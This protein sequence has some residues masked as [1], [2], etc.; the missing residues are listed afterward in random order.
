MAAGKESVRGR[1]AESWRLLEV[2]EVVLSR[3]GLC[4]SGTAQGTFAALTF[5]GRRM[6]TGQTV[7]NINML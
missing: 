1:P 5:R 4:C 7:P 6:G 2:P 3:A